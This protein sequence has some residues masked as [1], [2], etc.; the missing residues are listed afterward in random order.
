MRLWTWLWSNSLI[1][2]QVR[3]ALQPKGTLLQEYSKKTFLSMDGNSGLTASKIFL[4]LAGNATN[5]TCIIDI[6]E[7]N[8]S[9]VKNIDAN[10][11]KT[12]VMYYEID[13]IKSDD[14]TTYCI[15]WMQSVNHY[16]Y[17]FP[18]SCQ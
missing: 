6:D 3:F 8:Y 1:C 17:R 18:T 11:G 12:I 14:I 15:M 5:A 2:I 10:I 7:R 16:K 13:P 4:A 9:L